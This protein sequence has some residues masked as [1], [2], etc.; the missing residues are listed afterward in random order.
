MPSHTPARG[1]DSCPKPS[2]LEHVRT[3]MLKNNTGDL[4]FSLMRQL[5]AF[6][7]PSV[8]RA[9]D[10]QCS[11]AVAKTTATTWNSGATC[12]AR[13]TRKRR[14][15]TDGACLAFGGLIAQGVRYASLCAQ[16]LQH[17]N[18]LEVQRDPYLSPDILSVSGLLTC[19]V[20]LLCFRHL[21]S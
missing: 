21:L 5:N 12:C 16:L 19:Y 6:K 11:V 8:S 1:C 14:A 3:Q 13:G 4:T 2:A 10:R 20:Y 15:G 7:L 9:C 17:L 18:S